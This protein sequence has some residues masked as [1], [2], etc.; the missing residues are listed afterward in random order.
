MCVTNTLSVLGILLI[1]QTNDKIYPT[2][3]IFG[4]IMCYILIFLI[5]NPINICIKAKYRYFFAIDIFILD[6]QEDV[7]LSIC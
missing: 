6:Y 7:S 3:S 1:I 5:I 4:L 2:F